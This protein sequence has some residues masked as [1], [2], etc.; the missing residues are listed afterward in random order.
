MSAIMEVHTARPIP[1]THAV[2]RR[3]CGRG[4]GE[5]WP[6][7]VCPACEQEVKFQAKASAK[8][9]ASELYKV[10]SNEYQANGDW[11]STDQW[12]YSCYESAGSPCGEAA[13]DAGLLKDKRII[14]HRRDQA[15]QRK[16]K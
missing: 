10:I 1:Q 3:L 9:P 6:H 5:S 2:L 14:D 15:A 13:D 4:T 12:H 11:I 16:G 8:C 7:A